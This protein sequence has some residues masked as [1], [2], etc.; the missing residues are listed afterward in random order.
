MELHEKDL[1]YLFWT[2]FDKK[3]CCTYSNLSSATWYKRWLVQPAVMIG[4]QPKQCSMNKNSLQ[5]TTVLHQVW[6]PQNLVISWS[7][8]QPRSQGHLHYTFLS[9]AKSQP[10][11]C[12]LKG[13]ITGIPP[14]KQGTATP[15]PTILFDKTMHITFFLST[16][17]SLKP[18]HPTKQTKLT[19]DDFSLL[20]MLASKSEVKAISFISHWQS[21]LAWVCQWPS[22]F[23]DSHEVKHVT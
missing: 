2:F 17:F 1:T 3:W 9:T 12:C 14:R 5:I 6:P 10:Y 7:L 15:N 8:V 22:K 16:F 19:S 11:T 23:H 4:H 20:P 13:K 18:W 21:W